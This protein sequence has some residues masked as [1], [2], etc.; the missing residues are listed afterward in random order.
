[1]TTPRIPSALLALAL[2]AAAA[3][4]QPSAD[5]KAT[6]APKPAEQPTPGEQPRDVPGGDE[7]ATVLEKPGEITLIAMGFRASEGPLWDSDSG[8]LLVCDMGN[9][10][11]FRVP[12]LGHPLEAK[13]LV[14]FRVPSGHTWGI[15][16][17]ADGGILC[18]ENTRKVEKVDKD[19][20]NP[21]TLASEFEGHPLNNPN[22]IVAG[23]GAAAGWVYFTDPPFGTPREGDRLP[24]HGLFRV[25]S[26][27]KTLEA[28]ARDLE[29]PNGL[30][31]NAGFT[32]LYV[33]E[34]GKGII[35]EYPVK[36]DG[37]LGEGKVFVDMSAYGKGADGLKVDTAG[38]VFA[39]GGRAV[40][41]FSPEGK[42][43]GRIAVPGGASNVAF[44]AEDGKSLFITCGKNVLFVRTKNPGA[45]LP[46]LKKP[47]TKPSDT[48][49]SDTKPAEAKPGE[50]KPGAPKPDAKP[51]EGK[52]D[53][54]PDPTK[55]PTPG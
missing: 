39:T 46:W 40:Q 24:F 16:R 15:A 7:L 51:S 17:D 52:P 34:Y 8:S 37:A 19:G 21:R 26:D 27:G 41:V 2:I 43:L 4:A 22:D 12:L 3:L 23:G 6:P 45:N 36:P 5:P 54:R 9:D 28:L 1:M 53:T 55:T 44:G 18:A 30:A 25:S 29:L 35:H 33:T 32:K 14:N 50:S 31:F 20:T 49:P 38:N 13:E 10:G 48:K 47:E 11:I 42:R